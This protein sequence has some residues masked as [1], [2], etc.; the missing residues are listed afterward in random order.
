MFSISGC[1]YYGFYGNREFSASQQRLKEPKQQKLKALRSELQVSKQ[2]PQ[3][4]RSQVL[5]ELLMQ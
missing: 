2:E 5:S 4:I 1:R 3:A